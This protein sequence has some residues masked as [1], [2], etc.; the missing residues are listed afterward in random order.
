MVVICSILIGVV[1]GLLVTI[2]FKNWRFL[3][4]EVGIS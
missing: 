4:K 1:M 3:V 2:V